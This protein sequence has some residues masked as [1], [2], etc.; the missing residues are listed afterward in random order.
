MDMNDDVLVA[1]DALL[2]TMNS[3]KTQLAEAVMEATLKGQFTE[4]QRLLAKTERV[5]QLMEQ[6]QQLRDAWERLDEVS[7]E[8][9][10]VGEKVVARTTLAQEDEAPEIAI[11]DRLFGTRKRVRRRRQPV[12]KTPERAYRVPILEALEQ[13]GGRGHTQEVL[14]IVY[15]K[16]KDRLTE[17][18]LKPLPSGGEMRWRNTAQW[19]RH[20]MV[21]EGVL[22]DDSPKGVWEITEAGRAYLEQARRESERG[23]GT[24][25]GNEIA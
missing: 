5:E 14:D 23:I 6:V 2:E 12:N 22:R 25:T 4:A 16:M 18:D 8:T 11:A 17:D 13:L 3:H 20:N 7:A 10:A 24:G 21:R 15:E 1:F 9:F 19:E